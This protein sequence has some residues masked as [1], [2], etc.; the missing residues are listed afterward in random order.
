[1]LCYDAANDIVQQVLID[2][3][4]RTQVGR[5]VKYPVSFLCRCVLN[6]CID[7]QRKSKKFAE[8][9]IPEKIIDGNQQYDTQEAQQLIGKCLS[10]LS[11][12]DKKLM[13][14]YSEG[15]AY[16]EMAE[17]AEIPF[18]SVGKTLSRA[19]EKL[20]TELKANGY[21]MF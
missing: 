20:E 17:I 11:T 10:K 21:E 13:V 3:Y 5:T 12:R 14:L 8:N 19:L 9:A 4:Q 1:M 16:K 6:K 7:E 15:F 18:A 2:Y